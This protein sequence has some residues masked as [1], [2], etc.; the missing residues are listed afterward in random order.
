MKMKIPEADTVDRKDSHNDIIHNV[1]PGLCSMYEDLRG[2]VSVGEIHKEAIGL[3]R[4]NFD[5]NRI[6]FSN[7][8]P[9]CVPYIE[10]KGSFCASGSF[11]SPRVADKYER[12]LVEGAD[13]FTP[14]D[15]PG[16][17]M[18]NRIA[19]LKK[20]N[21]NQVRKIE[22]LKD[23][24][25][26]LRQNEEIY[27]EI[28][29]TANSI[30]MKIDMNGRIQYLN[31]YACNFFGYSKEEILGRQ[32]IGTI[33]TKTKGATHNL[34]NG[35]TDICS[36]PSEFR[37]HQNENITR[38]GKKVSIAWTNRPQFDVNGEIT[39]ILCVGN[40]IT[41]RNK[42]EEILRTSESL[43][44]TIFETTGTATMIVDNDGLIT[45]ANHESEKVFG[46]SVGDLEGKIIW[47]ALFDSE[48]KE[49]IRHYHYKRLTHPN[50]VPKKYES[51]IIDKNGII[52]GIFMTVSTIPGTKSSVL[53][54]L[55]ITDRKMAEEALSESEKRYR[56]LAENVKDIIWTMDLDLNITYI[57][58]SVNQLL[59]YEPAEFQKMPINQILSLESS[60]HAKKTLVEEFSLAAEK[61][62]N[63]NGFRV[64]ELECKCSDESNVWVEARV[65]FLRDQD[66][67]VIG[68]MGVANDITERKHTERIQKE[69]YE[70]IEKN[71]EQFAILND[72]IRNPLQAIVGLADLE[73]GEMAEMIIH[74]A[75]EIDVI[76]KKLDMGWIESA[77]IR[78]FIRKHYD[79]AISSSV[80]C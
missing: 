28:V 17:L 77:K 30:I 61:M 44:R 63:P 40:D 43:Y 34:R 32:I 58:P 1:F 14:I 5:P 47:D 38:H 56:L 68:L 52:R 76:I 15:H 6:V 79:K 20:N 18:Q 3:I 23:I 72:H 4:N 51:R 46:Y 64:L 75:G 50:E 59:G 45:L 37:H 70:Q 21:E 65:T 53:S 60:L 78:E 48:E 19:C 26:E 67:L 24:K 9:V 16:I 55:D 13:L 54:L 62:A 29:E 71:M 42:K 69:T 25:R 41:E 57:S 11:S 8:Q 12:N 27:R 7:D 2:E 73:G 80:Q 33:V 66:G 10:E 74:Q 31:P 49:R 39:S 22:D 35:I 36:S